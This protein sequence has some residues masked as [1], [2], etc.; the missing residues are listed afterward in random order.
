MQIIP[1]NATP[2][3]TFNILL[4]GQKCT[5][6]LYWR[7][8][9]FYLDLA[10]GNTPICVGAICQNRASIVQSTAQGLTQ[11]QSFAGSLHFFD[12]TGD[13]PPHWQGLGSR[14]QL[15]FIPE[16]EPLPEELRF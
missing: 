3:Q 14:F 15:L 13:A 16:G 7:Q 1:L 9:R 5:I 2:A 11:A 12:S 10:V 8:V 6:T 4:D